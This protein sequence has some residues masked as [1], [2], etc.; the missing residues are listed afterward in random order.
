MTVRLLRLLQALGREQG[1][2][3]GTC[4][5]DAG[6]GGQGAAHVE[7]MQEMGAALGGRTWGYEKTRAIERGRGEERKNKLGPPR[8]RSRP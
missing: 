3:G 7:R 1:E 4:R 5:K 8:T 2:G 6:D